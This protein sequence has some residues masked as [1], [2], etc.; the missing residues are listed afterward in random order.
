MLPSPAWKTFG[1]RRPCFS[2]V[3]RMK[4]M[5]SGS[6]ERGTT[7]SCVRKFGLRRPIDW[8]IAGKRGQ[9]KALAEGAEEAVVK[10]AEKVKAGV[11]AFLEHPY[12]ILKNIFRH[13]KVRYRGVAKKGHRF[14]TLFD[15]T[16]VVIGAQ[17]ATA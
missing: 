8:Q 17:Q 10:A 5:I 11:R 12:H 4:R 1:M 16:N 6:F 2:L 15:L 3:A 13:R 9:I 7:P 14:F